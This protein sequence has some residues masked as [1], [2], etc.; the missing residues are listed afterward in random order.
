MA[1]GKLFGDEKPEARSEDVRPTHDGELEKAGAPAYDEEAREPQSIDPIMEKRVLRKMD[2]NI[3]PL[4]MALCRAYSHLQTVQTEA[5]SLF[6]D[7]LAF[8]DRS[9]IG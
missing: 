2:R 3:I 8:L 1:L 7:L 9:N 6:Q 4:V 5:D